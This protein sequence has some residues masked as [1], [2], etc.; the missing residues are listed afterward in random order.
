MSGATFTAKIVTRARG[1]FGGR[2]SVR[3]VLESE[4]RGQLAP[5]VLRVGRQTAP[6]QS[7]RLGRGLRIA[8]GRRG[9]GVGIELRS[10]AQS[11]DGFPYTGVTRFGRGPVEPRRKQALAFAVGGKHLVR[12]RVRGYKPSHDWADDTMRAAEPHVARAGQRIGRR[13]AQGAV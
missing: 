9:R 12:K 7:G 6:R 5:Q 11:K 1:F 2:Q 10:T 13:I 4:F 8:V 3:T